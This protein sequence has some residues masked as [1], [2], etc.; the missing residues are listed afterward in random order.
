[1]NDVESVDK[2]VASLSKKLDKAKIAKH[3]KLLPN[4]WT[5]KPIAGVNGTE[6]IFE[7]IHF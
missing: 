7:T 2:T 5:N 1:M 3:L 6:V 4:L